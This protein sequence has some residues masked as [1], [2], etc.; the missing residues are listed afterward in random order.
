MS[1]TD[2]LI[3]GFFAGE[4]DERD[5][6][7]LRQRL[8]E[9]PDARARYDRLRALGRAAAGHNPGEIADAELDH[10]GVLVRQRLDAEGRGR[11]M[12]RAP[13]AMLGL[14]R[15][16]PA[17]AVALAAAL[18]L[19]V[20]PRT[21]RQ[22]D[23]GLRGGPALPALCTVEAYTVPGEA[24]EGAA[25]PRPLASGD[26]VKL[27][28]FLQLRYQSAD[29]EVRFLYVFGLDARMTPLD[30]Y[31][32]PDDMQSV[33]IETGEANSLGRSIRLEKRH[34]PGTLKVIGLC[35][36][37]ALSRDAVMHAVQVLRA[38]GHGI[39]AVDHLPVEG[40][41]ATTVL[42]LEVEP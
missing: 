42:E 18:L 24:A 34:Q 35:S 1:R 10:L 29:P 25:K 4:L 17:A 6:R 38:T 36:R 37:A 40:V 3:D 15:L 8:R 2:R 21:V 12:E 31:P 30:Y 7:E 5:E 28:D 39:K 32:R 16:W 19:V 13:R 26:H 11:T 14:G 20:W 33:A 9:D 22:G 23:V 27:S 41:A